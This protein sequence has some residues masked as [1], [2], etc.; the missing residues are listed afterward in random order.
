[1]A[2]IADRRRAVARSE[3]SLF[4]GFPG[5]RIVGYDNE[6]GKG[7]HRHYRT[8]EEVYTFTTIDRLIADFIGDVQR[9]RS[10]K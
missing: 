1:M 10:G 2:I 3:Y 9:E 5:E 8:R 6:R 4:Y 7:D